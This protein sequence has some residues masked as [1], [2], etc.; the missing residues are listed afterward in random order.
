MSVAQNLKSAYKRM[1]YKLPVMDK[2]LYTYRKVRYDL[3][4]KR[5]KTDEH[6]MV[7]CTFLGKSYGDTPRALYEYMLAHDE[8]YKDYRFVWSFKDVEEYA[9]L[10]KNPRTTVVKHNSPEYYQVTAKAKYWF[11]NFRIGDHIWPRKDQVYVE[12]WHGTPLK[13]LGFDLA[14]FDNAV[15]SLDS[16]CEKYAMD[17]KKMKYL[18]SP[19]PF[20]TEKFSSAWA[21]KQYGKEDVIIEKGYPRNDILFSYDEAYKQGVLEKLGLTD[22]GGKKILLYAPTWRDNQYKDGVGY[23]YELGVD[24]DRLQKELGDDFVILFRAHHMVASQFNF[25]KYAG[26]VYNASYYPDIADL[27]I[28]ADM[29]ATDY[30]S[31]FFDY[32]NLKRPIVFYMYDLEMYQDDIRGFYFG[33]EELPGP[34]VQKEDDFISAIRD[35]KDNFVYDEK[36]EKFHEKFNPLDDAESSKRVLDVILEE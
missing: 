17:T 2:A 12:C 22:I 30:S 7:F 10:A 23:T 9:Y 3:I 24:F 14:H 34:I 33:L 29:L 18:I 8:E 26:F 15:R 4:S 27:Y 16:L 21:L 1:A 36:Y 35:L 19:S 5:T 31:V 6:L 13:R 28:V 20:A 11:H 25:D 32:A